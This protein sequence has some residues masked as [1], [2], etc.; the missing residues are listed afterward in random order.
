MVK[1]SPFT[2]IISIILAVSLTGVERIHAV[3]GGFHL[4]GP[5]FEPIIERTIQELVKL[6]PAYVVPTHC[7]GR[8]AIMAFEEAMPDEFILN[9]SGTRLTFRA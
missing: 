7:T 8:K 3:M 6:E 9:M 2:V 5:T 1:S 4:A